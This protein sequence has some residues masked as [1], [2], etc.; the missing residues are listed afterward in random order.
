MGEPRA[1]MRTRLG[2]SRAERFPAE[3]IILP[4]RRRRRLC[5][6]L[7]P[8]RPCAEPCRRRRRRRPPQRQLP[9]PVPMEAFLVSTGVVALGEIGDKTQLLAL[10]LAARFSKPLPIIAGILVATLAN[11]ALAGFLGNLVR[12]VRAGRSADAGSSRCRSSPSRSGRCGPT[13]STTTSRRRRRAGASS[14]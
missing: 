14:A 1:V 9:A 4:A 7:A 10:V 11:H 12:D 8:F 6:S 3:P 2:E 13:S 5:G